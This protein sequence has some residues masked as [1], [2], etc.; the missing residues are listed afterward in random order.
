MVMAEEDEMPG[1]NTDVAR[2]CYQLATH[3]KELVEMSGGHFGL[4]YH[5]SAE[6]DRSVQV[7]QDF[8]AP[9]PPSLKKPRGITPA[10][11]PG[12]PGAAHDRLTLVAHAAPD[13][14]RYVR[15]LEANPTNTGITPSPFACWRW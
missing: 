14:S 4:L 9:L 5:D 15:V 6:F 10:R 13:A 1:A 2:H 12:T 7:Q 3:P 8:P 11:S